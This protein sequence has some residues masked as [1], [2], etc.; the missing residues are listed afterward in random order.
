MGLAK[1]AWLYTTRK[2]GRS[3][4]LF[5][6]LFVMAT[7]ML[8]GLSMRGSADKAAAA[9][10]ESLGSSFQLI[11]VIDYN[12]PSLW[13]TIEQADGG[14]SRGYN[15]PI[16]LSGGL[17]DAVMEV[18]GI[19]GYNGVTRSFIVTS[20]KLEPGFYQRVVQD[21]DFMESNPEILVN[22]KY[23]SSSVELISNTES[24]LSPFF[25]NGA[26]EL[27][28]G[29]HIGPGDDLKV[30]IS[31][32]VAARNGLAIGDTFTGEVS[33]EEIDDLY[34]SLPDMRPAGP[35]PFEVAGIYKVNFGQED[36]TYTPESAVPANFVFVNDAFMRRYQDEHME[37][38][39][40]TEQFHELTFFVEDPEE[41]D[42]VMA[43]VKKLDFNWQYLAVEYDD[44]AYRAAAGPL[45]A[46]VTFAT[47]LVVAMAAGCM[48]VLYLMISIWVRGRRREIGILRSMGEK[49]KKIMGQLLLEC[50]MVAAA[51]FICA[52]LFSGVV[53][54]RMG[55][56]A[57]AWL[58]PPQAGEPYLMRRDEMQQFQAVPTGDMEADLRYTV[59]AGEI[60]VVAAFEA[61]VII[62]SVGLSSAA[63]LRMSPRG[64]LEE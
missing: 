11:P 63:I 20:L 10:R 59:G 26:F 33:Q 13:I 49:N 55:E 45:D 3:I 29:R 51:A 15:M 2:K 37:N 56:A 21:R 40:Y 48:A 61:G 50:A 16:R 58:A 6:V 62:A 9:V 57:E 46:I 39:P 27:V 12:D 23:Y 22:A 7:F 5:L 28:Q 32:E 18:E 17:A 41:L 30:L 38:N 24:E 8:A 14:T 52:A 34:S 31:E 25:R 42:R 44:T 43:D 1:R 19:T 4:L 35:Y 64:I 53:T 36:T 60:A 54:G 47:V